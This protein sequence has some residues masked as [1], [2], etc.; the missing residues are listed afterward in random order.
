MSGRRILVASLR[1][2]PYGGGGYEGI[3]A[4]AVD[5]LRRRGHRVSV[6]CGRGPGFEEGH[7]FFPWL[8][9]DLDGGDL[10]ERSFAASNAERFRLHFLRPANYRLALAAIDRVEPDLVL[11]FN[12]AHASLGP[13]LAARHAGVATLGYMADPWLENHWLRA[14][15]ESLAREGHGDGEPLGLALLDRAWRVVRAAVDPGP[16][17]ACSR[18]LGTALVADGLEPESV[19]VAY[20]GLGQAAA[21]SARGATPPERAEGE[22][23]RVA[24]TS[25]QW[26]GK[27]QHVLLKGAARARAGGADVEV[28]LAGTG[29]AAYVDYLRELA[30]DAALEGRVHFHGRLDP[31][32]VHELLTRC[33][34]LA[35]PSLWP[36]PFGLSTAEGMAH[37][38]CAVGSDAG[39]TPELVVH[40]RSGLVAAAGDPEAWCDA[41]VRLA[42][43]EDLRRRLASDGRAEAL[44]RFDPD[45][46]LDRLEGA[47]VP[48][49][50]E[51]R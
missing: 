46:F 49:A 47:L 2:P 40:G 15:R 22:P 3:A 13:I 25:M 29:P 8:H 24:C 11:F 14:W 45:G 33:H 1:Y 7:E 35:L 36:E 18:W 42:G 10:F 5:G 38:L 34:V 6:L 23:L 51:P 28:H 20:P 12:L 19:E 26:E 31:G 9:P 41:L 43:D 32:A 21:L 27:G 39:A 17:L 16:L 44:A 30:S 50:G 4:E 37:G 48:L